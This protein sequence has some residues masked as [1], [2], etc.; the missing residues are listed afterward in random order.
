MKLAPALLPAGLDVLCG[1]AGRRLTLG[2]RGELELV[3]DDALLEPF[4]KALEP[5]GPRLLRALERDANR[6]ALQRNALFSFSK[7]PSSCL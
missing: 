3:G 4:R 7:K 6:D 5:F 2:V 1:N